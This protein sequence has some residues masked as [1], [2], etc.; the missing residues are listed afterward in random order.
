LVFEKARLQPRRKSPFGCHH[1]WASAREGSAFR[2]V[3]K[4]QIP[5]Y[6][7]DDNSLISA[8]FK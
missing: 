7:R 4:K 5:R 2:Q 6:A 1:E 3:K 8:G